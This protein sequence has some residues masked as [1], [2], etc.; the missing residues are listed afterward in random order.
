MCK[1][2]TNTDDSEEIYG[3][4][5]NV[6]G[7]KMTAFMFINP[8]DKKMVFMVGDEAALIT[9]IK[10]CPICGKKLNTD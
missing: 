8:E 4:T 3:N 10:H 5:Y 7:N 2:C 9:K 6:F 1:Y